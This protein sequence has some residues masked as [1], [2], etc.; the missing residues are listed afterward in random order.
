V[1]RQIIR[2]DKS[3]RKKVILIYVVLVCLGLF[4]IV[5]GLPR[6][7]QFLRK[8]DLETALRVARTMLLMVFLSVAALGLYLFRFG[9]SVMEHER[10]PPP[11]RKVI[12]DTNLLEGQEA[13]TRG[14]IL[15]FLALILVCLGLAGAFYATKVPEKFGRPGPGETQPQILGRSTAGGGSGLHLGGNAQSGFRQTHPARSSR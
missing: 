1:T 4:A 7:E 2:A 14:R 12:R 10:F 3:Y 8:L 5:W 13:I 6:A 15:V 11:N 9:R